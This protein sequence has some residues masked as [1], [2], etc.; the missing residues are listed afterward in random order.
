M[1]VATKQGIVRVNKNVPWV[2]VNVIW[3]EVIAVAVYESG[4]L[5]LEQAV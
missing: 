1:E 3:V 5:I 2:A 4:R